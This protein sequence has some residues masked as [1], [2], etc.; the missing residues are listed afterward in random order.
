DIS[1]P[2]LLNGKGNSFKWFCERGSYFN[3]FFTP[4]ATVVLCDESRQNEFKELPTPPVAVLANCEEAE[5]YLEHLG[6]LHELI[7]FVSDNAMHPEF[8]RYRFKTVLLKSREA[9]PPPFDP[10]APRA[11][12]RAQD[13]DHLTRI[14]NLIEWSKEK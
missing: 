8:T 5:R 12:Y 14:I 13:F 3:G 7:I 10:N 2:G 4:I 9:N 6:I 11:N 1:S